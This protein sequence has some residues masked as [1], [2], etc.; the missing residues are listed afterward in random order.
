MIFWLIAFGFFALTFL[1]GMGTGL[2][3]LPAA[4]GLPVLLICLIGTFVSAHFADRS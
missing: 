3:L 2:G 1:A 4:F